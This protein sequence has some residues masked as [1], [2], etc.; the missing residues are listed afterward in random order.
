MLMDSTKERP[1]TCTLE[2]P[3]SLAVVALG[4]TQEVK[5]APN[6][7]PETAVPAEKKKKSKNK[8]MMTKQRRTW[9]A[10]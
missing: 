10:H 1:W 4:V 3:F 8:R 9:M 7:V 2:V 5:E 6:M